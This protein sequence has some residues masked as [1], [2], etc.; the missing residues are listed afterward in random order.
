MARRRAPLVLLAVLVACAAWPA[1]SLA[2]APAKQ[3]FEARVD[4]YPPARR[5]I[6]RDH[7]RLA[8]SRL[9]DGA[10]RLQQ[11]A[12]INSYVF[13][14][15][16]VGPTR[17]DG[18]G[19]LRDG[20]GRCGGAATAMVELL[21]LAGIRSRHAALLGISYQGNHSLVQVYL[22]RG[23]AGLFDP[24]FGVFWYSRRR[25][26]PVSFERLLRDP[27]ASS[28]TLFKSVH[29]KR[30]APTDPIVPIA[31][32]AS[33]YRLRPG[34]A[35][36]PSEPGRPHMDWTRAFAERGGAGL[37][38]SGRPLR[39]RIRLRPGDLYGDERWDGTTATPWT[40]LALAKD[41]S[42]LTLPWAEQLGQN[43]HGF[44]VVH[45]YRL[46]GL[47]PGRR[48]ALRLA[49]HRAQRATLTARL[50]GSRGLRTILRRRLPEIASVPADRDAPAIT[51]PFTAKRAATRMRVAVSGF[52]R[53]QAV[54]F[55]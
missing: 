48:Y 10:R 27:G 38:N 6:L 53:L 5:A 17:A 21:H 19:G 33:G 47:V 32:I 31:G 12:A 8:L 52:A 2:A 40:R 23:R 54:R 51:I 55:R 35:E 44:D 25:R 11:A 24:T 42:G 43:P 45:S 50:L 1:V 3:E 26:R 9:P 22:G 34:Y 46:R 4:S 39:V 41:R 18:V 14:R 30:I 16:R 20:Y 49:L 29:R 28:R 7:L 36:H 37:A 13:Q 15:L